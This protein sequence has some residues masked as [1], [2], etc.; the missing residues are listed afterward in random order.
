M[1]QNIQFSME[2]S[3]AF[4]SSQNNSSMA[5]FKTGDKV[6]I[7]LGHLMWSN[8]GIDKVVWF[9]ARPDRVGKKDI[10]VEVSGKGKDA[11]Y[12]L[13]K[14]GAWYSNR[15]LKMVKVNPNK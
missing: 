7:T 6:E 13:K 4:I 1:A 3:G 2:I 8:D 14:N 11:E 12:S 9:D 5:K 15:Q 10:V